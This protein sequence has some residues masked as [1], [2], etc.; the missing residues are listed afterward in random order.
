MSLEPARGVQGTVGV[1]GG[2]A[3]RERN[4]GKGHS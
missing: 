4:A 1:A 2:G 3:H